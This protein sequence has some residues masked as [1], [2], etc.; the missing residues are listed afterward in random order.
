MIKIEINLAV[1]IYL[2]VSIFILLLW[3]LFE[4]RKDNKEKARRYDT[5]WQCPICFYTY[6]DSRSENISRCPKCSTLHSRE[7][8]VYNIKG[9]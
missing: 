7:E 4:Y 3:I 5:L 9:D 8:K 1:S 6:I 2:T